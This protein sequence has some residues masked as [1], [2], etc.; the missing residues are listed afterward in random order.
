MIFVSI[1]KE[2]DIEIRLRLF[3]FKTKFSAS[4]AQT[5]IDSHVVVFLDQK[6]KL[7]TKA[8]VETSSLL[9]NSLEIGTKLSSNLMMLRNWGSLIQDG[10]EFAF[11]HNLIRFDKLSTSKATFMVSGSFSGAWFDEDSAT[12]STLSLGSYLSLFRQNEATKQG[13]ILFDSKNLG[14]KSLDYKV[15]LISEEFGENGVKQG[16]Q[17]LTLKTILD[18]DQNQ[19]TSLVSSSIPVSMSGKYFTK[20]PV[21]PNM[22]KGIWTNYQTFSNETADD[23]SP[24]IAN[25]NSFLYSSMHIFINDSNT[26]LSGREID[27]YFLAG[28]Y[29]VKLPYVQKIKEEVISKPNQFGV[30][31]CTDESVTTFEVLRC[32]GKD[33]DGQISAPNG[34]DIYKN[35]WLKGDFIYALFEDGKNYNFAQIDLRAANIQIF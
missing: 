30:Y 21:G 32:R 18:E 6:S 34:I 15:T 27:E 1:K 4:E 31:Y 22:I 10:Q 28:D 5:S 29:L 26:P 17:E 14:N 24:Y 2:K 11:F 20:M 9:P 8:Q 25:K 19:L 35:V 3:G 12:W 13:I 7:V 23:E 16:G 33:T